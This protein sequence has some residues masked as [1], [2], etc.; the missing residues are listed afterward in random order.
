MFNPSSIRLLSETLDK[1]HELSLN[2]ISSL[3]KTLPNP[4]TD[5]HLSNNTSDTNET[6]QNSKP[7]NTNENNETSEAMETNETTETSEANYKIF[8]E[9]TE[10]DNKE[11]IAALSDS[12]LQITQ[13]LNYLK[14][15]L[16]DIYDLINTRQVIII[17]NFDHLKLPTGVTSIEDQITTLFFEARIPT[18]WKIN[19]S[20]IENVNPKH[21]SQ[22][23]VDSVTLTML[24]YFVKEKAKV[25]L[26]HYFETHYVNT[27]FID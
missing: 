7:I 15:K 2:N 11:L 23:V 24:N 8:S 5:V 10:D 3:E 22:Y 1:L 26:K 6:I 18:S 12:P 4:S 16:K 21:N 14:S 20:W 13:D 19:I 27:V 17:K 25:L 9:F